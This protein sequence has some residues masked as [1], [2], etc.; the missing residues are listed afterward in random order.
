MNFIED[1]LNLAELIHKSLKPNE[2]YVPKSRGVLIPLYLF[3]LSALM[4]FIGLASRIII[5]K[6][7]EEKK[8]IILQEQKSRAELDTLKAQ[9]NP[10]FFFNTLNTIY[11][12]TFFDIEKSQD[13]LLKLSKMMRYVMNEDGLEKVKLT[14]EISFVKNYLDLMQQRLPEN[15]T[16]ETQIPEDCSDAEIAPMILLTFVEN[17]FKHGISSEKS[18]YIFI[19]IKCENGT[20]LLE[21]ENDITENLNHKKTSGIGIENTVKRLN[22]LYPKKFDYFSEINYN[23]YHSSLKIDLK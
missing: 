19:K 8:N 23:R 20:L 2:P 15:V 5:K 4:Y 13:A 9:I 21:T 18:C 22:I 6:N 1:R 12:L 3:M 11:S 7:I 10:H 17:C 16:L 14:D